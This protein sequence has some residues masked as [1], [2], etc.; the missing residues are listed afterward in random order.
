[1]TTNASNPVSRLIAVALALA[2]FGCGIA[3]LVSLSAETWG[4]GLIVFGCLLAILAVLAQG[5]EH[6]ARASGLPPTTSATMR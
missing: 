4:V 6:F 1:M 5:S 2:A 3:G